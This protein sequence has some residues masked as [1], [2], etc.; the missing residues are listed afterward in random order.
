MMRLLCFGFFASLLFS[1]CTG[2]PGKGYTEVPEGYSYKLLAIGDG[3]QCASGTGTIVCEAVL[4]SD[5]DSIFFNSRY[6]APQG[7]YIRLGGSSPASGKQ[8]LANLTEGDSLS[9]MVGKTCF[10]REY[11][12]TLVP[13]FLLQD[14]VVKLDLKILRVLQQDGRISN[15]KLAEAVALSPTAVLARVQE[16]RW[17]DSWP[18]LEGR[19]RQAARPCATED[20]SCRSS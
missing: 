16:A 4:R 19:G 5:H 12:D 8:H 9:L 14:S 7:F 13:Y 11:F 17:R 2:S 1:A 15:L 3:R 10:F 18:A 20:E 6:H